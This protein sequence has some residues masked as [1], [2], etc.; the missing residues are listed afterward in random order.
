VLNGVGVPAAATQLAASI[1]ITR[2]PAS[3]IFAAGPVIINLLKAVL[4]MRVC[5]AAALAAPVLTSNVASVVP[6]KLVVG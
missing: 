4:S 5:K 2:F 6:G 3:N 1:S